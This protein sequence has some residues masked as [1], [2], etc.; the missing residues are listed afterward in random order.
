MAEA[1]EVR[2]VALQTAFEAFQREAVHRE[3]MRLR[4]YQQLKNQLDACDKWMEHVRDNMQDLSRELTTTVKSIRSLEC[5]IFGIGNGN[6][7]TPTLAMR[8]EAVE[9]VVW[10]FRQTWQRVAL[11]TALLLAVAGVSG[12]AAWQVALNAASEKVQEIAKEGAKER[13]EQALE[14]ADKLLAER[15]KVI[16]ELTKALELRP[17]GLTVQSLKVGS[18][19]DRFA[20]LAFDSGGMP[21]LSVQEEW[22]KTEIGP[23][24]LTVNSND[25]GRRIAL[26]VDGSD[27]KLA[28]L[29]KGITL[30]AIE[31][32]APETAGHASVAIR[33]VVDPNKHFFQVDDQ[34]NVTHTLP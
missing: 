29:R 15:D 25:A 30:P 34:G 32:W 23:R 6:D 31:L 3:E 33:G 12:V 10:W 18:G 11:V 24:G 4:E 28:F 27:T 1:I 14:Q 13:I 8:I 2:L 22:G 5:R 26:L 21:Y 17:Q 16:E 7:D 9:G 20:K 19:E